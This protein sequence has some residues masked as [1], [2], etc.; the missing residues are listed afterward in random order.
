MATGIILLDTYTIYYEGRYITYIPKALYSSAS[1][2]YLVV[3]RQ[4]DFTQKRVIKPKSY[5]IKTTNRWF[6]QKTYIPPHSDRYIIYN[7]QLK[8]SS[9]RYFYFKVDQ[10]VRYITYKVYDNR[11]PMIIGSPKFLN[12]NEIPR[13]FYLK[14][15][16]WSPYPIVPES[17][18][19]Y[20]YRKDKNL[21]YTYSLH[22]TPNQ[23]KI[24]K[25]EKRK[26]IYI[27]ECY[28]NMI[29]DPNENIQIGLDIQNEY[30][31]SLVKQ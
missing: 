22:T 30:G 10:R 8:L 26:D 15:D 13:T 21:S 18:L 11:P 29:F 27:I 9:K 17:V 31:Y 16:V 25:D 20:L 23:L 14:A 24:Y 4:P 2:R 19:V 28:F 12:W 7:R 5:I 3:K 6:I 1:E